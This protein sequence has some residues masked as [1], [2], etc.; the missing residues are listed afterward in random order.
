MTTNAV[1]QELYAARTQIMAKY[2]N[3]LSAYL[4]DA[5]ERSK[6]SGHPI[7]QIQQRTIRRTQA[8]NASASADNQ[9]SATCDQ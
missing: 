5:A 1:L 4:R 3:D 2:G 6:V 8:R 7:A 9:S